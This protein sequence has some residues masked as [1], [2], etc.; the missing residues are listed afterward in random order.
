MPR[1]KESNGHE[2]RTRKLFRLREME[3]A[4]VEVLD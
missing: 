4:V 2:Q 1:V 3:P